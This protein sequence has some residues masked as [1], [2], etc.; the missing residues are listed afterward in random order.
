MDYTVENV[1]KSFCTGCGACANLCPEGAI[2]MKENTE[3]FLYPQVDKSKCVGCGL[4]YNRCPAISFDAFHT[5]SP[6]VYA[7]MARDE[8]RRT[9]SSGGVMSLISEYVFSKGGIVFGVAYKTPFE[10][11]FASAENFDELERLKGSKYFQ[12]PVGDAYKRVEE[13]LKKGRLVFFS[14][15]PCQVAGLKTYLGKNYDNLITADIACHGVPS[16]KVVKNYADCLG[17]ADDAKE[18]SFM[19]KDKHQWNLSFNMECNDGTAYSKEYSKSNFFRA[20]SHG[21]FLRESCYNC[22][23]TKLARVGDF[24]LADY[25]RVSEFNPAMNDGRGTSCVF[26]NTPTAES[27]YK[28]IRSKTY[29]DARTSSEIA[30]KFNAAFREPKKRHPQRDRFFANMSTV[31]FYKNAER[32]LD[33]SHYDVGLIGYWY[34]TNYGSVITYY[35]LYKAIEDMGYNT[36][37]L[38]RPDKW[39]DGEPQNVFSRVFM[40]KY[41]NISESYRSN[42]MDKYNNLCDRF[43]V[44]S[45]QVW[46]VHAIRL[47]GYRFFLDFVSDDKV[48]VAY[49]PSFGQDKFGGLIDTRRNIAYLLSRFDGVSVRED[50]GINV[51]K[52][53]L[54]TVAVQMIDPIF[55]NKREFYE[56]LAEGSKMKLDEPYVLSYILDPDKEKKKMLC[57]TRDKLGLKLINLLD[58]RY[59]TFEKND[60]KLGLK[61]TLKDISEQDWIKLFAKAEYVI[62]DSHHGFA[63][64]VIFNKPAICIMNK[65]R[66]GTRFTSLM[67]WLGMTDRL[68]DKNEDLAEKNYLYLPYD[69]T[70]VNEVIE[71]KRVEA[72]KWLETNLAKTKDNQPHIYDFVSG[73]LREMDNK[74]WAIKAENEK[75]RQRI[76]ELEGR[77]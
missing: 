21:L 33:R 51:C 44:G 64:A 17:N 70:S 71:Q 43:V 73:R 18:I 77:S 55:L 12:A 26:L 22:S 38:D 16:Y 2:T 32:C 4:C 76:A 36:V 19:D 75:L 28:F 35:S 69:Y 30:V 66:G 67:K 62:T 56:E 3:G 42:E 8:H 74:L 60:K 47:T 29:R 23:Y 58:G 15:C 10:L 59:N 6:K 34:A 39:T 27:I 25:W 57:H 49:A 41:A 72:L 54:N 48:K 11:E 13:Q 14:A 40:N 61:N 63:M 53:E 46:T 20:L 1:G 50:T 5:S 9:A 52:N 31:P 45:D 37:I 7:T 24:T 68:V 65:E